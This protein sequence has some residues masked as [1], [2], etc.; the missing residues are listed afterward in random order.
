MQRLHSR[1]GIVR[2]VVL[3]SETLVPGSLIETVLH[4][5]SSGRVLYFSPRLYYH[6]TNAYS[7]VEVVYSLIRDKLH[8]EKRITAQ[9]R[10]DGPAILEVTLE[11]IKYREPRSRGRCCSDRA[12]LAIKGRMLNMQDASV[13]CTSH[14]SL[15]FWEGGLR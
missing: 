7:I 12:P 2:L 14:Q 15:S 8:T 11:P 4:K 3:S 10:K 1:Y 9:P 13:R 6:V 5:F